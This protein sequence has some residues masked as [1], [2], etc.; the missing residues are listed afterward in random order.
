MASHEADSPLREWW[1]KH[2]WKSR[3]YSSVSH[4]L[5]F[6]LFV[7]MVVGHVRNNLYC[8]Y[9]YSVHYYSQTGSSRESIA[10]FAQLLAL[11]EL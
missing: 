3:D 9:Y 2:D 4:R 1:M 11:K 7:P 10:R 6:S 8:N 5:N